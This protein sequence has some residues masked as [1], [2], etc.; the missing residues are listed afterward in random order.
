M[1]GVTFDWHNVNGIGLVRMHV[2]HEAE[3]GGEIPADFV[4]GLA[5]IIGTHDVPMLLHEQH[6]RT[7]SVHRNVVN[8]MTDLRSRVRN[9]LGMQSTVDRLPGLTTVISAE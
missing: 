7:G 3:V 6:V 2:D 5:R 1:L 9:I 8:T 4:P